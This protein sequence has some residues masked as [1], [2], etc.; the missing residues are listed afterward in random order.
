MIVGAMRSGTT[1]LAR[2]LGAHPEV[3]VAPQ[4]EVHFFDRNFHR[5]L[6][7][8]R[9]Q[10]KA[11]K[12]E[13]AV[14]EATQTYLY[15]EQAIARVA[16]VFPD[17]KMIAILRNPIDRAYSHYWHNRSRGRE[18][19]GFAEAIAAEPGRLRSG[20]LEDR[21]RYSYMDRGRY[22]Q[23]LARLS[24]LF[25]SDAVHLLIFEDFQKS[26]LDV[27]RD[28]CTFLG[29]RE[30]FEPP[31]IGRSINSFA[32]FRFLWVR[33]IAKRLPGRARNMVGRLNTRS[34]SYPPLDPEIRVELK[35]V[36]APD[37]DAVSAWLGRDVS[38]WD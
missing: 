31:A 30:T 7:W 2:H 38:D 19:L 32:T 27:Y 14:G 11:S 20:S 33:E 1:S 8:Y 37:I 36:F 9:E 13:P 15:D 25:P 6:S 18:N 23:Q 4:K 28:V 12:D 34:S 21:Y 10:F 5:G 3:F 35:R 16:D 22:A 17:I 24:R 26:P 29:V